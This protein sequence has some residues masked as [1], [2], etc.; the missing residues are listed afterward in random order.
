MHVDLSNQANEAAGK[1]GYT[2]SLQ[3]NNDNFESIGGGGGS[4]IWVG[5]NSDDTEQVLAKDGASGGGG[6]VHG[7][8][9]ATN[10]GI[11]Q[12]GSNGNIGLYDANNINDYSGG[13]GGAGNVLNSTQSSGSVG[14]L[15]NYTGLS[16]MFYGGGGGGGHPEKSLNGI[17]I[18]GGGN[19]ARLDNIGA[20]PGVS[21]T[22]G[23]GGG[24]SV[25]VGYKTGAVYEKAS[26]Q[27]GGSGIIILKYAI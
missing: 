1:N 25:D 17:G 18:H 7:S 27:N 8:H 16:D 20:T 23:G 14:K 13:G 15:N 26:G 9:H 4:G 12:F 22:G 3:T 6:S 21:N 5:V 2:S 11:G 10:G 24:S 19:G